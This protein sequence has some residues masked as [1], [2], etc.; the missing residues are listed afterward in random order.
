MSNT[1]TPLDS[2]ANIS[3]TAACVLTERALTNIV[4]NNELCDIL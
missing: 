2:L 4:E 1:T 3:L